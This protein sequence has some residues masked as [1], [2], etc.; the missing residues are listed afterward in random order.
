MTQIYASQHKDK[1]EEQIGQ[2][3]VIYHSGIRTSRPETEE[4]SAD[5]WVKSNF[6]LHL[7]D[8]QEIRGFRIAFYEMLLKNFDRKAR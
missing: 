6:E 7:I 1:L 4:W 5:Q 8:S 2:R 3:K